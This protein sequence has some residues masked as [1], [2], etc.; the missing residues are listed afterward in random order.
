MFLGVE[1]IY[2]FV[3]YIYA[4]CSTLRVSLNLKIY[5]LF[6]CKNSKL[7]S[8]YSELFQCPLYC[9]LLDLL[10]DKLK[11]ANHSVFVNCSFF[12]FMFGCNS[13]VKPLKDKFLFG[14]SIYDLLIY[15]LFLL[16]SIHNL[17]TDIYF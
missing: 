8:L 4:F 14:N 13:V 16:L 6:H 2:L 1:F 10:V 11:S 9:L 15:S 12:C 7:L 5:C 3:Y 17:C